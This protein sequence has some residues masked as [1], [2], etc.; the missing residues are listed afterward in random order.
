M[1]KM[2]QANYVINSFHSFNTC[3]CTTCLCTQKIDRCN[4]T[5]FLL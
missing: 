5:T 4:G 2:E 1:K 3:Q